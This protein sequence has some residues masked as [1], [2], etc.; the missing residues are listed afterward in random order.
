MALSGSELQE[1][2]TASEVN[3]GVFVCK[4][5]YSN[6]VVSPFLTGRPRCS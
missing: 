4:V 5:V 1:R 6:S 2:E 3:A